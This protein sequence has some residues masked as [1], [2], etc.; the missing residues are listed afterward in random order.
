MDESRVDERVE[1]EALCQDTLSEILDMQLTAA[2]SVV[3]GLNGW[4]RMNCLPR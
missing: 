2:M 3:Y 4:E 1:L